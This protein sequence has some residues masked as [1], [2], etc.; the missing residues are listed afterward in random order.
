M[1]ETPRSLRYHI[2]IFGASN[3]GKSSLLNLLCDQEV[4]IVSD[5][6]GT[7]TDPI[8]KNIEIDGVG[9]STFIDTAGTLDNTDLGSIREDRTKKVLEEIDCGIYLLSDK[10]DEVLLS[11]LKKKE[12]PLIYVRGYLFKE[13]SFQGKDILAFKRTEILEEIK[14][15]YL[16]N[17]KETS[18][19]H[20]LIKETDEVFL[21][22][23]P[24]DESA[25]KGRI[26]LPQVQVL[27]ELLDRKKKVLCISDFELK[28]TLSIL[29]K[30]PDWIITD[31][32]IFEEVYK[33]KPKESKLTSFS[34]LFARSKGDISIFK[35]G[36]N[37]ISNL[38]EESKI[39]ISEAC[40]H[41]P[42]EEDIGTVKIP[43]LLRKRIGESLQIDFARGLELPKN[44]PDYDLVIFCG[45]CMFSNT[46][47][48]RRMEKVKSLKIPVT[49][50]GLTIAYLK[51]ILDKVAL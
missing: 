10:N 35:E 22:V 30:A 13:E 42:K 18:I 33:R 24:Q 23:M 4:S 17:T 19:F 6:E 49:N 36:A 31:S 29:N 3:S 47:V 32:Q 44:L 40:S 20:G 1:N 2:G 5:K 27:R 41:A 12:M 16:M 48:M 8:Y 37:Y 38:N 39:L 25:P 9:A 14:K 50:Y 45:S 11:L 34:I 7:T 51:G 43:M 21:L 15:V 46:Q 26:I 28:S